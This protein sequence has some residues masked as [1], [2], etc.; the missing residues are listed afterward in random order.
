MTNCNRI[1]PQYLDQIFPEKK[2]TAAQKQ[3]ALLYAMGASVNEL[4]GMN[5]RHSDTVRKRL[6]ETTLTVAGCTE[7]K[8]LRT[9]T[10]IRILNLLL[11]K[12]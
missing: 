5:D 2:L 3:D 8:N 11:M 6:N 9:V 10:L 12:S 7:I 1:D 4:A